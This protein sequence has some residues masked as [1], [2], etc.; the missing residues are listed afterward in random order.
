MNPNHRIEIPDGV[1]VRELQGETVLLHLDS[2]CY[3]GL[4]E[5]GTRM[6]RALSTTATTAEACES[7]LAEFDVEPDRLRADVDE[8]IGQLAEAGL[9]RVAAL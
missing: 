1:L 7:L 2:E 6:W 9:V 3:F 8:L 4:D 5:V